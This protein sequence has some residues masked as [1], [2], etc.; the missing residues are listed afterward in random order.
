MI[1]SAIIGFFIISSLAPTCTR[2]KKSPKLCVESLKEQLLAT[3]PQLPALSIWEYKYK[4][5]T[6]YLVPAPC[7]DQFNPVYNLECEVICHP[8]GGITGKGDGKCTDFHSTASDKK[9]VWQ[10]SRSIK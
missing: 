5:N 2:V 4:G 3:P 8:D 1:K 9:L 7:C 10:D 6:V